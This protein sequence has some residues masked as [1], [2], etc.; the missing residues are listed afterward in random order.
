[1][2]NCIVVNVDNVLADSIGRVLDIINERYETNYVKDDIQ[3]PK[4]VGSLKLRPREI[5]SIQRESWKNWKQIKPLES[6]PIALIRA[7]KDIGIEL[8]ISTTSPSP[9]PTY[10]KQWLQF[11]ELGTFLFKPLMRR[12]SK[13]TLECQ[14]L[15]DDT[16]E[17][18]INFS[19]N[20]RV[21][22]LYNQPWNPNARIPENVIRIS[23]LKQ[24]KRHLSQL[25]KERR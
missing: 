3:S 4:L 1:M 24:V 23:S 7:L 16:V 11:Y 25:T 14:F 19:S 5:F 15:V 10:M 20:E 6:K 13:Y 22:F 12:N 2:N 21:A 18:V 8:V 9:I 17:E